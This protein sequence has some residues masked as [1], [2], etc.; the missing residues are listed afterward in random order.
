MITQ[1]YLQIGKAMAMITS[2]IQLSDILFHFKRS[3]ESNNNLT[4]QTWTLTTYADTNPD[5]DVKWV[6]IMSWK[7]TSV[8][9][10]TAVTQ[11]I[12]TKERH[13]FIFMRG[14]D[15]GQLRHGTIEQ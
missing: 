2:D 6:C 3:S 12:V 9:A 5:V 13:S 8:E 11:Q 4:S 10:S 1:L 7:L 15:N 14:W